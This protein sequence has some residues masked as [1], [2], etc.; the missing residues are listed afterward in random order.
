[1]A[2]Y[3]TIEL[4]INLL[5]MED[6]QQLLEKYKELVPLILLALAQV[7]TNATTTP[8]EEVAP[9]TTEP[10]VVEELPKP[11]PEPAPEPTP[12]MDLVMQA[13][14]QYMATASPPIAQTPAMPLI[15]RTIQDV[16][17]LLKSNPLV[18]K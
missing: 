17:K 9:V 15:P 3:A 7:Q 1:M 5:A 8:V 4:T 6:N 18:I 14:K 10:A 12:S 13:V 11:E 2:T 16:D